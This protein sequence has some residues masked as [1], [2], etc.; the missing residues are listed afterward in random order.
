M[1]NNIESFKFE[2]EEIR[3]K[4]IGGQRWWFV[5]D[6]A[7][8]LKIKNVNER[9][10]DEN[11]MSYYRRMILT[12]VVEERIVNK[13]G[14]YTV[15]SMN[16]NKYIIKRFRKWLLEIITPKTDITKLSD[17]RKIEHFERVMKKNKEKEKR[18]EMAKRGEGPFLLD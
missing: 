6:I 4:N 18:I 15:M 14:L 5:K 17:N 16:P 7:K 10:I 9:R 1:N 3:T 2:G 8:V 13:N 11:N 12:E